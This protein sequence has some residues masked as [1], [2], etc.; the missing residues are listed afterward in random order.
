M[1][2]SAHTQKSTAPKVAGHA[3]AGAWAIDT[4]FPLKAAMLQLP[5]TVPQAY[6]DDSL[7]QVIKALKDTDGFTT[8]LN[9]DNTEVSS[10]DGDANDRI[11]PGAI[12]VVPIHGVMLKACPSW[13]QFYGFTSTA[14]ATADIAKAAAD[15]RIAK[16]VVNVY[17]PGGMVYGADAL[18]QTVKAAAAIKRVDTHVSDLCASAGLFGIAHS[19]SIN[20]SSRTTEM[21]SIGTM[22]T[23]MNDDKFWEDY[24]ITMVKVFASDSTEKNAAY[25]EAAAGKPKKMVAHLDE[26]N[27]V[28]TSTVA[29]GRAGKLS[30]KEDVMT[31]KMYVGQA[32][33]D[34]GLAD[35][36]ATLEETIAL[37]RTEADAADQVPAPEQRNTPN[38]MSVLNKLAAFAASLTSIFAKTDAPTAQ[39]LENA[40]TALKAE[41]ITGMQLVTAAQAEGLANVQA[42]QQQ[43][44]DAQ[45]ASAALTTERDNAASALAAE[46]AA[47]QTAQASLTEL[48]TGLQAL[49]TEHSIT[50]AE[51]QSLEQTVLAKAKEW[52][53][54][55]P[56]AHAGGRKAAE[57]KPTGKLT[58]SQKAAQAAGI[59]MPT[60]EETA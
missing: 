42:L 37:A 13:Y 7:Q 6:A 19:T 17:T 36:Y 48:N 14:R 33:I 46:Q 4:R 5:E 23:V 31:G 43:L 9:P 60:E 55:T 47:H 52:A 57:D 3:F 51:G 58:G 25:T 15:E 28:F 2:P 29:E 21:G 44:A 38:P 49:A 35:G 16:V 18:A 12:A 56:A 41:G 20:L 54:Q 45:T 24:G 39:E 8:Y 26:L 11:L 34:A 1:R 22:T 27:S 30:K 50:A 59:A 32:A 40:N 10:L 53:A